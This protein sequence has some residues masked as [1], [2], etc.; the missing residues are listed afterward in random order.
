MPNQVHV[1]VWNAV[2]NFDLALSNV[3]VDFNQNFHKYLIKF[4][5]AVKQW[6]TI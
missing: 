6:M 2:F 4:S 5:G 3:D 1:C